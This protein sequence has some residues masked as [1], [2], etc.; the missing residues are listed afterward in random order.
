MYICTPPNCAKNKL[1]SYK[2][3]ENLNPKKL[4]VIRSRIIRHGAN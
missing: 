1:V 4:C 3:G 2:K